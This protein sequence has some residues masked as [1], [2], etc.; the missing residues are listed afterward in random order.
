M[1]VVLG[2]IYLIL[3]IG[4]NPGTA[5][6][7]GYVVRFFEEFTAGIMPRDNQ[8]FFFLMGISFIAIFITEFI[9]N[10]TVVL[11]MFPLVLKMTAAAHLNP[12]FYLLAVSTAA[13]AAFMTPMATPV[14]A[15]GY[16]GIEGVSLK[17]MV[18]RGLLLNIISALWLT[19]F[20]YLLNL[21][22]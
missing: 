17:R 11:I 3:K 18:K 14:N 2:L 6:L 22:V 4:D 10:T 7:D 13:S 12:L 1:G 16:A 21:W 19:C 9:N 20:F 5:D 8:S 15:I